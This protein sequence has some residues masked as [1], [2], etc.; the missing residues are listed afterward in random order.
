MQR[1]RISVS[2]FGDGMKV[3]ELD[4]ILGDL[5]ISKDIHVWNGFVQ[6]FQVIGGIMPAVLHRQSLKQ[7]S[8]MYK[9]EVPDATEEE[10]IRDYKKY[11][12]WE[13]NSFVTQEDI[14]KGWYEKKDIYIIEPKAR[15]IST[16]DRA[17]GIEY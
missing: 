13:F 9:H 8:M 4:L 10:I 16:F 11:I 17:G 3:K 2:I 12:K 15:G 14:D 6:D 1:S 5:H 7:Y